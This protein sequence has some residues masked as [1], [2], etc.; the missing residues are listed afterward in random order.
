M[1]TLK[2]SFGEVSIE[3]DALW[4]I[5]TQRSLD[6]FHIG[7]ESFSTTFIKAYTLVKEACA[8][9]NHRCGVLAEEKKDAI[10]GGARAIRSHGLYEQFPLSIW[11][12]GSGTHTNMNVNEVIVELASSDDLRLSA[13]DDVNMSQSTNDTFPTVM[14]LSILMDLREVF[15]VALD[16]YS[17]ELEALQKR[18]GDLIKIGRT[19]LQ[20]ATPIY[21]KDV[22]GGWRRSLEYHRTQLDSIRD[23]LL[24]IPLGATAV[25]SGIN[26][27]EGYV[28]EVVSAL[29]EL[30]G[31]TFKGEP[32]LPFG[33]SQKSAILSLHSHLNNFSLDLYKILNDMRFLASGPRSGL[34]EIILPQNEA[35]SSI[36]PGKVNPSQIE[37]L[38]MVC[39]KVMGHQQTISFCS[40]QGHFELNAMMPVMIHDCL[41]S[42]SLLAYGLNSFT[43]H[44]LSGITFNEKKIK[45][46]LENSLMLATGLNRHIGYDQAS[47]IAKHAYDHDLS[48][49]EASLEMGL[50]E[51]DF[52]QWTNPQ[53]LV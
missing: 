41:K 53:D 15:D 21:F 27:P 28:T 2:D 51:E 45:E 35:G 26:T 52:D 3:E 7:D 18:S 9:A 13:N 14:H 31:F 20:D 30:T 29:S 34:G 50:T 12:T 25:G 17:E 48:L 4:G 5:V 23:E 16:Y 24:Y 38:S 32:S 49:R 33:I 36:M 44:A 10:S 37:A 6:Y 22:I 8:M 39:A 47:S 40:S 46:H 42:I 43:K 19:H 11:Q 1:K